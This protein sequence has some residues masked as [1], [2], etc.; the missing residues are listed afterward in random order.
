MQKIMNIQTPI[1]RFLSALGI[2]HREFR[3]P[4]Q[5]TSLQQAAQERGQRPEQVVRSILFRISQN[6]FVMVLVSGPAQISWAAL[7]SHL[8][9]SRLSMA[10]Q[11]EVLATTGYQI[12]AVA[13]FGLPTPIKILVDEG[14]LE[15]EEISVGSGVRGVTVILKTRDFVNALEDFE[16]GRFRQD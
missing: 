3:H 6:E 4:G 2:N 9:R 7:R 11:E 14:V 12:G 13:P 10:S 1:S 15:E 5:I 8:G 16:I